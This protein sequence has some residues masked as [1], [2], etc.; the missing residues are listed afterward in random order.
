[1]SIPA[2]KRRTSATLKRLRGSVGNSINVPDSSQSARRIL[3]LATR[4]SICGVS[5]RKAVGSSR[6]TDQ[7]LEVLRTLPRHVESLY[8]FCDQQGQ[9]YQRIVKG[10]RQ[11]CKR[12]GISDFRF[13]DLCHTFASH[14]VMRGVPLRT[15]QELVGHKTGQMTLRY[16]H[17]PYTAPAR[18]GYYPRDGL[19]PCPKHS[20]CGSPKVSWTPYGHQHLLQPGGYLWC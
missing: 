4:L 2:S 15:M 20:I 5:K 1:M 12:A 11:A 8:V 18:S 3:K 10:F 19:D 7:A 13:H 14:L 9:P 16:T 6:S 17:L